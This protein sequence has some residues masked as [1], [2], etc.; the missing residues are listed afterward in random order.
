MAIYAYRKD[1]YQ[2]YDLVWTGLG[3]TQEMIGNSLNLSQQ[4]INQRF[5][6]EIADLRKL[7]ES[8]PKMKNPADLTSDAETP[9]PEVL[10]WAIKHR[11]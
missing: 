3:W 6:Q 7:V 5:E 1:T 9:T 8:R 2:D 10:A 11:S 4:A